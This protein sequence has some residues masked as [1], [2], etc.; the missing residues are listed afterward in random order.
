MRKI[1][2]DDFARVAEV[3]DQSVINQTPHENEFRVMSAD[4]TIAMSMDA[5]FP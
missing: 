1:H 2:P 4:G 5:L 3:W